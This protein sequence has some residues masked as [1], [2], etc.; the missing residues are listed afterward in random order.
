MVPAD[1]SAVE[2]DRVTIKIVADNYYDALRPDRPVAKRYRTSPG[3]S[4]HAEH[5][6]SYYMETSVGDKKG[7]CMFDFGLD[8]AG[9][10]NNMDLLAVDPAK[11]GAFALS[12]GHFDHWTGAPEIIRRNRT[13][14][15]NGTPFYVGEEAFLHR[16]SLNPSTGDILDLGQLDR[17]E[18]EASGVELREI[19][20][21]T[22][23]IPGGYLSGNIERTTSYETTNP[24][25]LVKR[26]EAPEPDDFRGEQALFFNVRGKGLVVV[27]G[28]GH[29]G[30]VN[31][32]KHVKKISGIDRVHAILGGFHLI[33]AAREIIWETI[34]DIQAI[35]PD[36][37]A[38]MH[39][40]GFEA[41][42]A[43]DNAMPDA[44]ILNTAGTQYTF[45]S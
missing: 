26:G 37:V 24:K 17:A 28:C 43:F 3:K 9:V 44:F 20:H 29:A 41:L 38:P 1:I 14:I 25:L 12:H 2:V 5:G 22:E 10:I 36:H 31:T 23:M 30:I 13:K 18:I 16:Y 7:A 39:C 33:G 27:S 42:V 15:A 21:P 40:T 19:T 35:N 45:G 32:V 34:A 11:I 4:I 6:L 8:P